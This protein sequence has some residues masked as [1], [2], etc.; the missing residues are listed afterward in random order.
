MI[1]AEAWIASAVIYA[2]TS[3]GSLVLFLWGIPQLQS[4]W[5]LSR[6]HGLD[7]ASYVN[8][9]TTT[10]CRASSVAHLVPGF[11]HQLSAQTSSDWAIASGFAVPLSQRRGAAVSGDRVD[12][13]AFPLLGGL[14]VREVDVVGPTLEAKDS[15]ENF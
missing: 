7:Y 1:L 2:C 12:A 4:N 11:F 9:T 15:P 6:D 5:S 13:L 10:G 14:S 8:V 3:F